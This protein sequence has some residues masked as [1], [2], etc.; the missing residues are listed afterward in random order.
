MTGVEVC[1]RV[2]EDDSLRG[3]RLILVTEVEDPELW[4]EAEEA[5]ADAV[6]AK[7]SESSA[8]VEVVF[9]VIG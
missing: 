9:G 1:R 4:A 5:G 8:M 3:V 6:M 2:R 7:T